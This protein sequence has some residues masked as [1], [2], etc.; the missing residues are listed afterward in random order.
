M[1][2]YRSPSLSLGS[3]QRCATGVALSGLCAL[4]TRCTI[5]GC[6]CAMPFACRCRARYLHNKMRYYSSLEGSRASRG[7]R[8]GPLSPPEHIM[9]KYFPLPAYGAPPP[10]AARCSLCCSPDTPLRTAVFGLSDTPEREQSN[11]HTVLSLVNTMVGSTLVAL[12]WGY[13]ESGKHC[14]PRTAAHTPRLTVLRTGLL[15]G[16]GITMLVGM[17]AC[18]TCLLIVRHGMVRPTPRCWQHAPRAHR[19]ARSTWMT[20][21]TWWRSTLGR[22]SAWWR[23]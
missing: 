10:L 9:R 12:P 19:H 5:G 8:H 22:L 11:W 21:W 2:E 6:C 18:Y 16:I 17:V 7:A 13:Y 3:S 15:S 1:H 20:L 4:T 23:A 14:C